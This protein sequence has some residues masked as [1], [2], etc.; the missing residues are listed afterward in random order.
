MET[1]IQRESPLYEV[2]LERVQGLKKDLMNFGDDSIMWIDSR[3]GAIEF[4]RVFCDQL[5]WK[6]RWTL[7]NVRFTNNGLLQLA[8]YAYSA[9]ALVKDPTQRERVFATLLALANQGFGGADEDTKI[10]LESDMIF[11]GWVDPAHRLRI[12]AMTEQ[13]LKELFPRD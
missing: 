11:E 8:D 13:I 12:H 1:G 5:L 3:E 9:S 6:V 10:A 7:R 2:C 4:F